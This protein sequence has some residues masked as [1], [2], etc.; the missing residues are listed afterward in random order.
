[1]YVLV[2]WVF[3]LG[4]VFCTTIVLILTFLASDLRHVPDF[5][6]AEGFDRAMAGPIIININIIIEIWP[7]L[8]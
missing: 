2:S 1:M 6:S 3:C 5:A 4:F 8:A 7:C